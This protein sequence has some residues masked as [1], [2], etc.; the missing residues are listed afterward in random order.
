MLD[1]ID[2]YGGEKMF[3]M[4]C[5]QELPV[6]AEFCF[7]CGSKVELMEKKIA[8]N[9]P[10]SVPIQESTPKGNATVQGQLMISLLEFRQ[11]A[12]QAL[13]FRDA[14]LTYR[15][16]LE[17]SWDYNA[18]VG[19][20]LGVSGPK[21]GDDACQN[22]AIGQGDNGNHTRKTLEKKGLMPIFEKYKGKK[23]DPSIMLSDV[24]NEIVSIVPEY[25]EIRQKLHEIALNGTGAYSSQIEKVVEKEQNKDVCSKQNVKNGNEKEMISQK[26]DIFSKK[27][28]EEITLEETVAEKYKKLPCHEVYY[29]FPT[30][31]EISGEMH[32]VWRKKEFY[33]LVQEYKGDLFY[34]E[35]NENNHTIT[36]CRCHMQEGGKIQKL[37]EFHCEEVSYHM[38]TLFHIGWKVRT[39]CVY[40][41]RIYYSKYQLEEDPA[42]FQ[43]KGNAILSMDLN[44]NDLQIELEMDGK[45]N[46]LYCTYVLEDKFIF[47]SGHIIDRA[48]GEKTLIKKGGVRFLAINEKEIVAIDHN[49]D[50]FVYDIASKKRNPIEKVYKGSKEKD[51]VYIDGQREILYY[52]EQSSFGYDKK[53]FTGG[54]K[55]IG[56]KIIGIAKNGDIVDIWENI[57]NYGEISKKWWRHGYSA[58]LFNGKNRVYKI[59]DEEV[60]E[61]AYKDSI[62]EA[63]KNGMLQQIYEKSYGADENGNSN[64][65]QSLCSD[66]H[67]LTPNYF[68]SH[69]AENDAGWHDRWSYM[70]HAFSLNK[71]KSII[72]LFE[73]K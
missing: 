69:I 6:Q 34:A 17:N 48:T 73:K 5:G 19:I 71:E 44:G 2:S 23:I 16:S 51:I 72:P 4:N 67:M 58:F 8:I 20:L 43:K 46:T 47:D 59:S 64:R 24:E 40:R 37:R 33:N 3:C 35:Y 57:D 27:E 45:S 38:T 12:S 53:S 54:N 15:K 18:F 9:M 29:S 56:G 22:Y 66:L 49:N 1:Y 52:Y 7:N 68:I 21:H 65:Y 61:K 50:I 60:G 14:L 55:K 31:C 62:Y 26:Q 25:A 28:F 70:E 30:V 13:G 39:F 36:F 41:D 63:D 10:E 32:E 11:N 42:S